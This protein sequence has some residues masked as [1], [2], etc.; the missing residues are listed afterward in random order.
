MCGI[1]GLMTRDGRPPDAAVLDRLD[2]ALGHRGPDGGGRHLRGD[3]GLVHRRL[4]IIDLATGDQPLAEPGGAVLVANGEIYNYREL[5]AGLRETAFATA[6]DCEPPLHL[7]RR[8]GDGFEAA[9]RGMYAFAVHDPH[10]GCLVLGRDPFG[11][12]P[13]Y[14][15]ETPEGFAFASE[16]QAL[17]GAGSVA[18]VVDSRAR[19]EL[20]QLQFT[21][22]AD[23][24][25]SGIRR[26]LPGETLVVRAG[27]VVER[28]R[29]PALPDGTPRIVDEADALRRL[30]AAL[31]DSVDLHQRSDVPYG[32]FLSGGVDSACLLALMAQLNERPVLAF[33]AGFPGTATHDERAHAAMLARRVGAEHVEVAVTEAD[34]WTLL[35]EIAAAMDD[36]AADYAVLPTYLLGRLAA[37][38]VKVVLS[39]E[40]GDELFAGYGRY[41]SARRPAWLGGRMLRPRGTF[42]RFGDVLR[43]PLTGWRDGIVA[44][45]AHA[46]RAG[47]SRLQVAQ[48][49]DCADWL[50][51]DLL[52]KVDRCLMAHGVEGRVPFLDPAVAAVAFPLADRLKVR[53]GRGKY[54]LRRWLA[55]AMPEAEPFARKRGFTVPVGQWIAGRGAALGPLVAA[56]P[57]VA[58]ICHPDRVRALFV[59]GGKR[60]G[61]AAWTLLF[62][63]LWHRRHVLG[64]GP[65]GDVFETLAAAC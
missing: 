10:A 20:L 17:V 42:D 1:A 56:A 2:A 24:V 50:P 65:D 12:K 51:H 13:L 44:A 34:F 55:E 62:Y 14:Y 47:R 60:A 15:A 16:L 7:Y 4:A 31:R 46:E 39:G 26:V 49:A 8:N 57:G 54:L 41:R 33:T 45:T 29:R 18:P 38:R 61:F 23:T 63:A 43:V 30:D 58:E 37:S 19:A 40:G 28:R 3:V 5:R 35:P 27:R 22:G 59:A 52:L 48:A 21:T 64:L 32:M 36:P 53:G 11:I 6:S 25:L 9:L